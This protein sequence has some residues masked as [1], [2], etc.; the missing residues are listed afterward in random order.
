MFDSDYLKR[1]AYFMRSAALNK[2]ARAG[3]E[4]IASPCARR[5]RP[6]GIGGPAAA[7]NRAGPA[8][9]TVKRR[10][11]TRLRKVV[12]AD[13]RALATTGESVAASSAP[14]VCS[15]AVIANSGGQSVESRSCDRR[16][17]DTP[18]FSLNSV[19]EGDA[20]SFR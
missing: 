19:S 15:S 11:V 7:A 13:C 9:W 12:H 16:P 1:D 5:V 2:I 20:A 6:V 14:P 17:L 3:R 18:I 8:I 4:R 10:G